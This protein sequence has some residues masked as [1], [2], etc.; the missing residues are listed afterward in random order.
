MESLGCIFIADKLEKR[1]DDLTI[2]DPLPNQTA[3]KAVRLKPIN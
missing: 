1:L 2:K 3:L